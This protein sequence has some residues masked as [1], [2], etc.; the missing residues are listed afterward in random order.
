MKAIPAIIMWEL[1]KRRNSKRHDNEVSFNKMLRQ[2]QM[3]VYQMIKIKYPWIRNIPFQ[4]S[5]MFD[6]LQEYRPTLYY[7]IAHWTRPEEGWIKCNTDG[8]SKGN[9]G[10]SSYGFCL[11]DKNGDVIYAE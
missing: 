10:M 2:C 5:G 9:P 4:W 6:L 8:A 3:T 1:W 11:R 7:R